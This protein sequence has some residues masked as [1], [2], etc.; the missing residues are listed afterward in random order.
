VR[1]E[2]QGDDAAPAVLLDTRRVT[3]AS[4]RD[5]DRD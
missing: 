5:H 3:N 1:Q 4:A 2:E